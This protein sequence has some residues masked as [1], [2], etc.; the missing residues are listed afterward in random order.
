MSIR[1]V[2]HVGIVVGDA[3][4]ALSFY[5]DLLELRVESDRLEEGEFI[6]AI[7]ASRG[8]RVRTIKL[9]APEGPT[10]IELLCF[11]GEGGSTP[12]PDPSKLR[13][14][15]PTHAALTVS[16]LDGLYARLTANG[17]GFL[18]A[19]QVSDD[20]RARVAFCSDPEGT[21]LELVEPVG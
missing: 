20:G 18:S 15:G 5:R 8:V 19:P 1:A 13:R 4:R 10:L 21:L 17:V 14:A 6:D 12:E 3:E 7:L 2:R 11:E 16:D 9:S